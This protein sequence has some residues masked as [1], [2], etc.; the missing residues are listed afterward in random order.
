MYEGAKI[1]R[2]DCRICQRIRY[3]AQKKRKT[4]G[5]QGIAR[6]QLSTDTRQYT[7]TRDA[8][9]TMLTISSRF[10]PSCYLKPWLYN[11][12]SLHLHLFETADGGDAESKDGLIEPLVRD[13]IA[14]QQQLQSTPSRSGDLW[15]GGL[16]E[17]KFHVDGSAYDGDW[18]RPQR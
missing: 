1:R 15:S 3:E 18:G 14:F 8:A 13:Y 2:E 6:V 7:W 16:N 12:S 17:P 10:L 9:L 4:G 5:L 11:Q